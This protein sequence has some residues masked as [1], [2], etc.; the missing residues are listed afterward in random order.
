MNTNIQINQI[1][2]HFSSK[3][4]ENV[5]YSKNTISKIIPYNF[6]S[7][8]EINIC[9]KI[10]NIP[11]YSNNYIVLHDYDF[12]NIGQLSEKILQKLDNITNNKDKYLLFQYK[13]IKCIRFDDFI[14]NLK[15][16]KMVIFNVLETFSYLLS[17]LITLNNNN[18]CF[19]NLSNENI[20]LNFECGEKPILHNFQNSLQISKL[21]VKYITNIIKNTIDY[22]YKPLEVNVL[23]YLIH[24]ELDTINYELIEDICEGY[25]KNLSVL[26]LFSQQYNETFKKE[27]CN[28]LK[29]YIDKPKSTIIS[30]IMNQHDTWDNYS[31]CVLYLHIIGNISRIF[32]LKGTFISNFLI[33]LTKNIHPDYSKREKL[34][35]TMNSYTK[36]YDDLSDWS[37]VNEIPLEKMKILFENLSK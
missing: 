4:D 16:P 23:F 8:N 33:G 12:V 5:V 20:V 34:Q 3:Q 21:S 9:E 1:K 11:Y 6:F 14:F 29:K 28:S 27:C 37:F 36:L 30:D 17:S 19:F 15:T 10:K 26:S 31:L 2:T 7:I 13:K 18:I 24:N 35:D 32:S 25:V 22:T